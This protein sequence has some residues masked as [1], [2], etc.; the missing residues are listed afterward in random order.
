VRAV[1]DLTYLSLFS[2]IGGLDLGLDRAGWTC[3]GQV[4][5][6]AWCRSVLENQWPEA[7]KHDDVRTAPE[8]WTAQPRPAVRMVAGG[9]PCQPFSTAGLG[10]GTGDPRWGWPWFRAVVRAVRPDYVLVENVA[11]LLDDA[12]A[13]GWLLGDLAADGF[14]ADW[15]VLSACSV[16]APHTRER[17]FL[18]AHPAGGDGQHDLQVPAAV[19]TGRPEP[20]GAGGTSW[21]AGWLPEPDVGRMADGVPKPLVAPQLRGLGNAV[22]PDVG[23]LV[24]RLIR[25]HADLFAVGGAR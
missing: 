23:E 13:F 5:L 8:W 2:G 12:D 6:D 14:D 15:T 3:V 1:A 19:A 16:G 4:E 7:P 10:L 9:F 25:E 11:A 21:P 18:V 24:G 20:G 17:L 22:V